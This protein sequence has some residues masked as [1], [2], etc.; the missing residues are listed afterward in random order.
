MS[1]S[2]FVMKL[3]RSRWTSRPLDALPRR[4]TF[5]GSQSQVIGLKLIL[6]VLPYRLSLSPAAIAE[7]AKSCA[8]ELA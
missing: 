5:I 6:G 2:Y 4:L 3:S 1:A 8:E 7:N